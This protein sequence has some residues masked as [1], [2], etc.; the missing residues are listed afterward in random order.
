MDF[1]ACAAEGCALAGSM[2]EQALPLLLCAEA[3]TPSTH[4]ELGIQGTFSFTRR[5]PEFD[6]HDLMRQLGVSEG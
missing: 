5:A 2:G 6:V 4:V 1:A 3:R